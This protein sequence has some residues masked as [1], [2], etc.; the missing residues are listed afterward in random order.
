[1]R[2]MSTHSIFCIAAASQEIHNK[3]MVAEVLQHDATLESFCCR[4]P[5]IP[6]FSSYTSTSCG[7]EAK[8]YV[9]CYPMLQQCWH[10]SKDKGREMIDKVANQPTFSLS[11]RVLIDLPITKYVYR[12]T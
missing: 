1:M 4:K 5:V 6:S 8:S 11:V 10:F 9:K 2:L 3:L 7:Y 12:L